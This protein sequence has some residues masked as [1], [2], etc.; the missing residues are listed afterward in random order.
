MAQRI[1]GID[2]GNHS[3]KVVT[4]TPRGKS[5]ARAPGQVARPA[6]D[7]LAVHEEPVPPPRD[8]QDAAGS[9]RERQGEALQELKRRGAL[10]G[11]VFVTGVPGDVTATRTLSFPFSD[12]EKI[13]EALPYA[14]ESELSLDIDEL[15]FP[16]VFLDR[17]DK[18]ARETQVL[19][20]Y[21][22]KDVLQDLLDVTATVGV[23]PRHVELDAHALE[24]AWQGVL[25]PH[26]IEERGP[27]ELTTTGGTVIEI[28]DGAPA[29]A[30]AV[31]DIGHRRT[32]VCIVQGGK[33]VGVHTLLH[34]GADATRALAK[35]IGLSLDEAERGKKKESFI[36]VTGA[37]AQFDEQRQVSE[38]LK[39]AVAPLVRRLRQVVQ[40]TI[41][42]SRVRVVKMVI[43]GG[44]SK[45]VNLDRH[46]SEELNVK[47]VRGKEIATTLRVGAGAEGASSEGDF[48]QG[49][50]A[51]SYALSAMTRT[52][53]RLDFRTGVYA[54]R[55]DYDFIKERL[56]ALGA[57]AAAIVFVVAV[58]SI[59][60]LVMLS[61][62]ADALM[63]KQLA[64]CEQ[65][66]GQ[67]TDSPSRCTALIR[68][69][70]NGTAGFQVPEISA[71]DI[72][73][74]I[75]QRLPYQNELK[76]KVTELDIT[77]ERVRLK[78]TTTTYEA[79]DTMVQRLQGGRCFHLVEKGKA[80]N[81]N[82]DSVE[83]NITINL[84]CVQAPGDGK[85]FEPPPAPTAASL[86]AQRAA[87]EA[88][89]PKPPPPPPDAGRA[90]P[91]P[92]P[93]FDGPPVPNTADYEAAKSSPEALEARRERLKRLRDERAER[94]RQLLDNPIATPNMRD[95]FQ[96]QIPLERDQGDE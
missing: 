27:S 31:V 80:R 90:T 67:K 14:L 92:P 45:I 86:A 62:E 46:L 20:A 42:T 64:L 51:L 65:I 84:D 93:A 95:R 36:E 66:T 28:A 54:F 63:N 18:D 55:G 52:A 91:P 79:I 5:A 10:D 83:M 47:V 56:P 25:Y 82:A 89:K 70:I 9:L 73:M 12:K 30:V 19:T 15:V 68:E 1:T 24:A 40:S 75:S 26:D 87:L 94:R 4:I 50:L 53:S 38:V 43:T 72:F 88:S 22:R 3:V 44:G 29:P 21:T 74:E 76:R 16:Y 81:I 71:V 78:G 49:A 23:D 11:E 34:G 33:I 37:V 48:A 17:K 6:F 96:R 58:G 7:V 60:Q 41:S 85:T 69:R 32:S 59:A 2:L 61:R 35:E 8:D 13:G 57:W 77:S 39:K